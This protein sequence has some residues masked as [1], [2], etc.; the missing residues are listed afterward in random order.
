M[1]EIIIEAVKV[2]A[3]DNG[4]AD[5]AKVALV[6]NTKGYDKNQ[7]GKIGFFV[8][9]YPEEFE[10]TDGISKLQK[11][12]RLKKVSPVIES[13]QNPELIVTEGSTFSRQQ[14]NIDGIYDLTSHQFEFFKQL[15]A[16][17]QMAN[18]IELAISYLRYNFFKLKYENKIL[19]DGDQLLWNI[20]LLDKNFDVIWCIGE[21]TPSGK[22]K[23][24]KLFSSTS[25]C[26]AKSIIR[27]KGAPQPFDFS[28][29]SLLPFNTNLNMK[30]NF[31]HILGERSFRIPVSLQRLLGVDWTCDNWS[32]KTDEIEK[33]SPF[34]RKIFIGSVQETI[35]KIDSNP[36][37]PLKYWYKE[38]NTLCW[39]IPVDLG[40]ENEEPLALVME[41]C[42]EGDQ[43]YYLG[44]TI[45]EQTEAYKGARLVQKVN[46][47][48]LKWDQA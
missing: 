18:S 11:L 30:F 39:L 15:V 44:R 26:A 12:I 1:I 7:F 28:K 32:V 6:A 4:W 21:K 5:L 45:L 27:F 8:N 34:V 40:V 23:I 38:T 20:G 13:S 43:I 22:A 16:D 29:D 2:S 9:S 24:K 37:I 14:K 3:P 25:S 46:S 19:E 48:W 41:Q 47:E 36:Q 33:Y 35:K 42:G 31:S 17:K 10:V